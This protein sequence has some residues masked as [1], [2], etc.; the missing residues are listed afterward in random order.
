MA[1]QGHSRSRILGSVDRR[2]ETEQYY[3][4]TWPHFLRFRGR[5]VRNPQKMRFRLPAVVLR[6][7]FK[8][9]PRIAYKLY[10]ARNYSHCATSLPTIVWVYLHSNFS[11]RAPK[12]HVAYFETECEMTVPGHP[13]SIISVPIKSAY[14]TS[15]WSSIVTLV[16]SCPVSEI[17]LTATPPLFHPK[18]PLD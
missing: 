9:P 10:I 15:Y 12:T 4:I 7:V 16:L 2:Q 11:G 17:L 14:A 3:I 8:E 13:R 1:I 5:S 18:F 6:L